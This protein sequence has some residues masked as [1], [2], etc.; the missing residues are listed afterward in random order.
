MIILLTSESMAIVSQLGLDVNRTLG[1]Y[2]TIDSF[3]ELA[4]GLRETPIFGHNP[5]ADKRIATFPT[6]EDIK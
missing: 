6:I 2:T 3:P 4:L 1:G 5:A